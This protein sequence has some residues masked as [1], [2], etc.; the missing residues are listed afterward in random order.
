MLMRSDDG[1]VD[2]RL[3][4]VRIPSRP[5]TAL[6]APREPGCEC[7][8]SGRSAF[9]K[10]VRALRSVEAFDLKLEQREAYR[11]ANSRRRGA[12]GP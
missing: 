3:F 2:H 9:E 10:R 12:S 6:R 5:N 11:G 8:S 1:G 7:S 4:V